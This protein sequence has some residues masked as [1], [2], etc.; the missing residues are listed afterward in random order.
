L[1]LSPTAGQTGNGA[2]LKIYLPKAIKNATLFSSATS[3]T[4]VDG[5]FTFP[6]CTIQTE[7][8]YTYV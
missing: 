4:N 7:N 3:C 6:N 5:G 2:G 1:K 8:D